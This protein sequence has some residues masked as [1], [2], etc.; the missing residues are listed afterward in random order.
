MTE[1][2]PQNAQNAEHARKNLHIALNNTLR[3]SK[4]GTPFVEQKLLFILLL[5]THVCDKSKTRE[6]IKGK[7]HEHIKKLIS[8]VDI[9]HVVTRLSLLVI[10]STGSSQ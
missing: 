6:E 10:R 4:L 2:C 8:T 7:R 1:I 5:R 9:F 3:R